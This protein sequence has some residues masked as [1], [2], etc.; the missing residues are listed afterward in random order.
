[1][2]EPGLHQAVR[3]SALLKLGLRRRGFK[4]VSI[5]P[6]GFECVEVTE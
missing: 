2:Y 3:T 1:M 5:G 6:T 4:V